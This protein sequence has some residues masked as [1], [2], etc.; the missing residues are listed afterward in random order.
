LQQEISS[1]T[2]RRK[3]FFSLRLFVGEMEAAGKSNSASRKKI[4]AP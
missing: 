4:L 1:L 2:Q 3:D